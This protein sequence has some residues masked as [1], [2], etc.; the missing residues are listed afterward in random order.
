M[1]AFQYRF[2]GHG[3][4][5][6]VYKNGRTERSRLM[7]VKVTSNKGRKKPR[8][9]V[10]ISKKV[11]KSAVGRNRARRR[12]YEIIRHELPNITG[13]YDVVV[14]VSSAEIIT[15]PHKEVRDQLISLFQQI[16]LYRAVHT[17]SNYKQP[18]KSDIII[19][20]D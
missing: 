10:V 18:Q 17:S 8:F 19:Y 6:Y 15:A 5:R 7:S 20:K 12:V 16:G 13:V 4:L 2:H 14:I 11:H 3:S 9:A 1:L